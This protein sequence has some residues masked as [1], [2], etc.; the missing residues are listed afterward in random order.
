MDEQGNVV[1]NDISGSS[2]LGDLSI[3]SWYP[4]ES[5]EYKKVYDINDLKVA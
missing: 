3:I 5:N 2:S 4:S 1:K